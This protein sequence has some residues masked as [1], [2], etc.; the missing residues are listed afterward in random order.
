M[1]IP[2]RSE[3][4]A[5][6]Q[7][8]PATTP[9]S[10]NQPERISATELRNALQAL[11]E[12]LDQIEASLSAVREG[13]TA[14]ASQPAAGQ[15][16]GETITIDA[17]I[18]LMTYDDNGQPVYKVKGG[19]YMKF[20]IRIWPEVLPALGVDPATLKPGPNPIY[21]RVRVLMGEHGPRKVVSLA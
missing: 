5:E 17:T 21:L 1:T 18:L 20:G 12:R 8:K 11:T 16:A 7:P 6:N 14:A 10:G 13:L 9:S 3:S 15:P 4:L 19:Q 2:K